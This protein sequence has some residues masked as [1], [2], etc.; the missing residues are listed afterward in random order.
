MRLYCRRVA[1]SLYRTGFEQV[2]GGKYLVERQV[3]YL[4]TV[5]CNR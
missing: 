4:T 3:G 5:L 1:E 2:F